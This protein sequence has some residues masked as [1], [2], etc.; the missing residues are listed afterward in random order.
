MSDD[1]VPVAAPKV[2]V[3]AALKLKLDAINQTYKLDKEDDKTFAETL[4]IT[5]PDPLHLD[6]PEDDLKREVAIYNQALSA[7]RSAQ[8][9]MDRIGI[10]YKR[11]DDYFA[12][13]TKSDAHMA[14]IKG[15][16]L[17]EHE[18]LVQVEERR[19][20]RTAKKFGKQVQVAKLQE[21]AQQ[22]KR[23]INQVTETR[24]AARRNQ[25]APEFDVDIDTDP[26]GVEGGARGFGNRGGGG[27]GGGFSKRD[28][29]DKRFGKKR[30]KD[31]RNSADSVFDSGFNPRTGS[32]FRG[33]KGR[34][35]GGRGSA[36]NKGGRGGAKQRPGKERRRRQQ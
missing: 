20:Q 4:V 14:R 24:K 13:M 8:S 10:P 19:K 21:R 33:G 29:K 34:S 5:A 28:M 17:R 7:V 31:K 32:G 22:R 23:E 15:R 36:G 6:D 2:H 1:E 11:P 26:G 25:Q 16:M 18:N 35:G 9:R 3:E 30:G 12:E 27:G